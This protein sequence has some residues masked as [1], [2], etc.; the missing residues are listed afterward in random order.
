MT[1]KP[2]LSP[3]ART[4]S[5]A[6]ALLLLAGCA[7]TPPPTGL[8]T[9]AQQQLA[10]AQKAQ[11][12]DYDPV[13]LGFAKK[14]YQ[15]AQAAMANKKYDQAIAM[16]NESIADARL[17]RTRAELHKVHNRIRKQKAENARLRAQLLNKPA[18]AK[19]APEHD[20]N[21]GLPSQIV[22]PQPQPAPATSASAAQGGGK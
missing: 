2:V 21:G 8:M 15:A 6:A 4:L 20:N 11:A 12:A 13:D 17:A 7:S 22:L 5:G 1:P 3:R 16:A 19:P 14:R 18:T 10:A 9:R